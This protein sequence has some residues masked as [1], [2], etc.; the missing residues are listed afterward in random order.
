MPRYSVLV[1]HGRLVHAGKGYAD[2]D[3]KR[4]HC[5][6]GGRELLEGLEKNPE[7]LD[8]TDAEGELSTD[9]SWQ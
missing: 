5:Y 7:L 4:L 6:L 3:R 2:G 8:Q 1:F 9:L